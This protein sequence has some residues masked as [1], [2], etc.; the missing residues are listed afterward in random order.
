MSITPHVVAYAAQECA[1]QQSGELSVAWMVEGWRYAYR[2]RRRAITLQHILSLAKIVEPRKN[3]DGLRKCNV[4]VGWSVKLDWQLVPKALDTLIDTQPALGAVSR[5]EATEW[6]RQYEEI[7]PFRDGNGRT[8]TL[9]HNWLL[10]SLV[11][12]MH[13]PNLWDDP[14]R[15]TK[16]S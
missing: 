8:G 13:A 15:D 12:P 2:Y 14:R 6:F 16:G 3:L 7:H 10:G 1:W 4:R 5:A 9:L 11:I